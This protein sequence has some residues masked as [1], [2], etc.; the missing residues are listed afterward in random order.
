MKKLSF[1]LSVDYD[2]T[3]LN[4]EGG[5]LLE[6]LPSITKERAEELCGMCES[7]MEAAKSDGKDFFDSM[8]S[9]INHM[10]NGDFTGD[11]IMVLILNG[12]KTSMTLKRVLR[13]RM[14]SDMRD[15]LLSMLGGL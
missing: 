6:V 7:D 2:E 10:E 4:V 12:Y 13:K 9:V 15:K 14:E 5:D 1:V 8:N 11:D 3:K